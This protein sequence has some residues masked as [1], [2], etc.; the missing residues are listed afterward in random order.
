LRSFQR[1]IKKE[2]REGR[3][4]EKKERRE[5]ETDEGREERIADKNLKMHIKALFS[6]I[7]AT[8]TFW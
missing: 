5:G 8:V 1:E 6:P 2:G 4:E 3:E 7:P